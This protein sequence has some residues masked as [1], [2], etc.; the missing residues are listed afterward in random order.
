MTR[1]GSPTW[2]SLWLGSLL[3]QVHTRAAAQGLWSALIAMH[4]Q[5]GTRSALAGSNADQGCWRPLHR[6][7][8]AYPAAPTR[9]RFAAHPC[10]HAL[11][12]HALAPTP[13]HTRL[14]PLPAP[15]LQPGW[16]PSWSEWQWSWSAV[17]WPRWRLC[18]RRGRVACARLRTCRCVDH[19]IIHSI[20]HLTSQSVQFVC[21]RTR[22]CTS[23]C[24]CV[25]RGCGGRPLH[26]PAAHPRK[27]GWPYLPRACAWLS[28]CAAGPHPTCTHLVTRRAAGPPRPPLLVQIPSLQISL[29]PLLK[30]S[31]AGPCRGR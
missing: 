17:G 15:L 23:V 1:P 28:A 29:P 7:A 21:V 10:P 3:T 11:T 25:V 19:S 30:N 8:G 12:Q 5:Y 18:R 22:A 9:T 6:R 2:S 20:S 27:P 24:M 14:F 13:L 31:S 4:G 16:R 26:R